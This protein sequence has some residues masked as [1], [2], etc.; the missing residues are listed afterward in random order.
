[1]SARKA[2]LPIL[3]LLASALAT[4][5]LLYTAPAMEPQ[6]VE[7][8]VPSVHLQTVERRDVPLNLTTHGTV[9]ARTEITLVAQVAGEVV[10]MSR[11]FETGGFFDRGEVLITLDPRDFEL[12]ARRAEA[13]V[14]QARLAL[15]QQEAE[16]ELAEEEWRDV[17]DEEPSPL[18]LREPQVA[19]ARATLTA[20]EADLERARLDLE[21]TRIRAPFAGRVRKRH[22]GLGE[23]LTRGQPTAEIHAT[24]YAEVR[25]PLPSDELALLDLP[26]VYRN[27]SPGET[28]P[29]VTLRADWGGRRHEW[30]GRIVRTE[31][32]VDP[33]TR[34]LHLVARVE[35]PYDRS[36]EHS[37]RSP[38][39]LGLFVEAEIEGRLAPDVVVLPRS[40]LR[41]D[42]RV[43][44]ADKHDR[45]FFRPVNVLATRGSQV[46]I[47]AGLEN[48]ERVCVSTLDL[49]VDGMEVRPTE[50]PP[51][52]AA[53][54]NR[55]TPE[56]PP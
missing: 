14:A 39:A 13:Q 24:N 49:A 1:M 52:S 11:N 55:P 28:G 53:V 51:E 7:R 44:V 33:D 32:E 36:P 12:A 35:D 40:A 26:F 15:V 8:Q 20:A 50:V 34:M 30:R 37:L 25:L 19:Q 43:L 47:S 10:A 48:G 38:L 41:E 17:R 42:S 18:A 9:L 2:L 3:V 23:F 6:T 29:A 16:A 45:L 54:E 4:A 56:E 27:S 5:A 22:T 31:G 46:L 21:R